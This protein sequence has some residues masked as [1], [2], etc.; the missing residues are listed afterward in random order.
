V[1]PYRART[2]VTFYPIVARMEAHRSRNCVNAQFCDIRFVS[3]GVAQPIEP[4]D[5]KI[6]VRN[7]P[8]LSRIN[9]A[10]R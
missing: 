8:A 7:H 1:T 5:M 4:T 2:E 9:V 6:E 3:N 10:A